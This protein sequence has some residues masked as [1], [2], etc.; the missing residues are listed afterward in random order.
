MIPSP[1]VSLVL[2]LAVYRLARLVGWDTFPLAE[3]LR[4]A[5]TGKRVRYQPTESSEPIYTYRRPTVEHF[6]GC[7]FCQGF[8][9]SLA[10]YGA[11]LLEPRWTL[12][13][14]APLALSG[15]VGLVAKNLDP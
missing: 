2:V 14:L 1:F 10:A 8:W 15:A 3:R 12:Y 9:L 6:I 11:W 7:P 5:V 13:A 4:D